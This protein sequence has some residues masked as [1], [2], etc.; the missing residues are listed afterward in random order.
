MD[1]RCV[2]AGELLLCK[3]KA[4]SS[5]PVPPKKEKKKKKI[6]MDSWV[7]P[8]WECLQPP[9][10]VVCHMKSFKECEFSEFFLIVN[11]PHFLG[12]L[13]E[14][15]C[16]ASWGIWGIIKWCETSAPPFLAAGPGSLTIPASPQTP[17]S[18]FLF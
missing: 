4:L 11:C 7:L 16:K 5:T 12:H 15:D 9:G 14:P 8:F 13:A 1:W 6:S 2:Q 18:V 3:C 17:T 10:F